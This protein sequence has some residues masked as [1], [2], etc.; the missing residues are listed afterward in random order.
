M[1]DDLD[2]LRAALKTVPV[3]DAGARA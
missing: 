1:T 3:P 2:N